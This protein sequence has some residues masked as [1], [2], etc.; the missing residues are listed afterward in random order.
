MKIFEWNIGMAAT[1][2]S[3]GGYKLHEWIIDEILKEEPDCVVLTEFVVSRGIEYFIDKLEKKDYHWFISGYTKSNGILIALKETSFTFNDT[4]DYKKETVNAN[5][6]VLDGVD[7]PNFYEIIVNLNNKPLSIIGV[8]IQ[9]DIKG[10]GEM[11]NMQ[12]EALDNYLSKLNRPVI[13]IGDFNVYWGKTWGTE[14][15]HTLPKTAVNNFMIYTPKYNEENNSY[16]YVKD[17][18]SKIQLDHLITNINK[19]I[20]VKYDWR[21]INSLRYK[22]CITPGTIR[23]PRGL[24]DHAI[25]K[26]YIK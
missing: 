9:T 25:L 19:K 8:R 12:F 2:P 11:D 26:A 5:N 23:K 14:K 20:E 3:N 22:T 16:S 1:I 13:C 10:K 7:L 24:P 18:G 21:F 4:F 6:A 15:N 17:D